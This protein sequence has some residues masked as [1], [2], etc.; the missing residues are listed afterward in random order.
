M[1]TLL[2]HSF[3]ISIFSVEAAAYPWHL[4]FYATDVCIVITFDKTTKLI[5][6][7]KFF[8][9]K[10]KSQTEFETAF[11]APPTT[12][13]FLP[14]PPFHPSDFLH[15]LDDGKSSLESSL[16]LVSRRRPPPQVLLKA[17]AKQA[18]RKGNLIFCKTQ[19]P[20]VTEIWPPESPK[21]PVGLKFMSTGQHFARNPLTTSGAFPL[22]Q[23]LPCKSSLC[24]LHHSLAIMV[25]FFNL[26]RHL[27]IWWSSH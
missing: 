24:P 15:S 26:Q 27:G 19:S 21:G 12:F 17:E 18:P 22:R 2:S 9:I 11:T 16:I 1:L 6:F 14:S 8:F 25:F 5:F 7:P 4:G 10:N 20:S 23:W 3:P 13:P